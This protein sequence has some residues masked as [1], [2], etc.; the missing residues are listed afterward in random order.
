MYNITFNERNKQYLEQLAEGMAEYLT[1]EKN[2]VFQR[3]TLENAL[4][5]TFR[6]LYGR[7]HV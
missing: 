3:E 7:A 6:K 5:Y 4:Q 2:V 1:K